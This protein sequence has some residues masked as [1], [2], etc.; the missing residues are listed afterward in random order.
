MSTLLTH[1]VGNENVRQ[2]LQGL[3]EAHQLD[4]FATSIGVD[5]SVSLDRL[6]SSVRD[7]LQRRRFRGIPRQLIL[8]GP[9]REI[10]RN[11]FV[12]APSPRIRH[13]GTDSG[14]ASVF[15]V[16]EG[17]TQ[18][19]RRRMDRAG[20][21]LTSVYGYQQFAV[22]A[23][24]HAKDLGL[25]RVLELPHVHWQAT[26][27]WGDWVRSERPEWAPTL[28]SYNLADAI[29]ASE[30]REIELADTIVV[31]SR[32]VAESVPDT[33]R[34]LDVRFIPYG[35]PDVLPHA[36]PVSWDG[37]G[38][39]KILFVGRVNALKGVGDVVDMARSFGRRVEVTAYGQLPATTFPAL[40]EFLA[41]VDYRGTMSRS[42]I[43]EDMGR[44]HLL[45]LPSLAE[46]RSLSA[47]EA[48]SRGLPAIV[49]PG[50]GVD[51]LVEQGAGVVVPRGDR[52]ALFGAVESVL[53]NPGL[54]EQYSEAA[55][56][57]ARANSWA[58]FRQGVVD[59][60]AGV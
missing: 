8:Q 46:G 20:A 27:K 43:M 15:W 59:V 56:R 55:L 32:Q 50:T 13:L 37:Q 58:P 51:D 24:E 12:K 44:H 31:P 5:D 47:L 1:P 26:V 57:I 60:T 7:I 39:L 33:D 16:N 45:L 9:A 14:P 53:A 42:E 41:T 22:G 52:D 2:A 54:V 4:S 29:K 17:V 23:F 28:A 3:Y 19:A 36:R 48:L 11:I 40:D 30:D 18:R 49:T 38:P 25:R 21:D 35:T 34:E 6:P 10:V